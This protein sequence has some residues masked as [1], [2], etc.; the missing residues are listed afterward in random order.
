MFPRDW[1]P[2]CSF[3]LVMTQSGQETEHVDGYLCY[4]GAACDEQKTRESDV[5]Y[6]P[7][8]SHVSS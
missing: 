1:Q 2:K 5:I 6:V 3:V 8:D 7:S 4:V